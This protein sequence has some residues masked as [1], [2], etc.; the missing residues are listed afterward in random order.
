MKLLDIYREAVRRK[1]FPRR[2]C[3]Q[4]RLILSI[5][6]EEMGVPFASVDTRYRS[7][8]LTKVTKDCDWSIASGCRKV[9]SHSSQGSVVI[10]GYLSLDDWRKSHVG[11]GLGVTFAGVIRKT[12][13]QK[14]KKKKTPIVHEFLTGNKNCP[15]I[16]AYDIPQ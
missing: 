2:E 7:R 3:S 5:L 1:Q 16:R 12:S 9:F 15:T 8:K 13:K 4:T 6:A 10:C 14:R 11:V